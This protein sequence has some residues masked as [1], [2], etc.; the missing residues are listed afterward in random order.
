MKL[1][2][3]PFQHRCDQTE[4][5]LVIE[6]AGGLQVSCSGG[7]QRPLVNISICLR[8]SALTVLGSFHC[9]KCTSLCD[10]SVYL[11][12]KIVDS[13]DSPDNITIEGR[14]PEATYVKLSF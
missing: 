4:G 5:G 10:V 1:W 8:E 11:N 14:Y 12:K 3:F 13:I 2:S 6:M 7:V 9:P